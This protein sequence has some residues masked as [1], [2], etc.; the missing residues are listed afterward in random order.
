MLL[1]SSFAD[2]ELFADG[3][4]SQIVFFVDFNDAG[5]AAVNT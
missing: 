2:G 4:R 1:S 3:F 5:Q